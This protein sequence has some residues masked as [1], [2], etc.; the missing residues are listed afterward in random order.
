VNFLPVP[1]FHPGEIQTS[2]S[3]FCSL[4]P[5]ISVP[6]TRFR[7][8]LQGCRLR[9]LQVPPDLHNTFH[10]TMTGGAKHHYQP[11]SG[12]G[13]QSHWVRLVQRREGCGFLV[14]KN[15]L[16][17]LVADY[18]PDI[19][20]ICR[21]RG[22]GCEPSV[23]GARLARR[24]TQALDFCRLHPG[25]FVVNRRVVLEGQAKIRPEATGHRPEAIGHWEEVTGYGGQVTAEFR[26][27]GY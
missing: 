5:A 7:C 27:P 6:Y 12:L 19:W 18:R 21:R 17:A 13:P 22:D 4:T 3:D 10:D 1:R 15:I 8:Q 23:P 20:S 2:T 16:C 24:S 25:L 14:R 11:G 26:A 9:L